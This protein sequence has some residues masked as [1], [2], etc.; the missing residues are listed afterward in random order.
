MI[1]CHVSYAVLPVMKSFPVKQSRNSTSVTLIWMEWSQNLPVEGQGPV[2]AYMVY[3]QNVSDTTDKNL[4]YTAG[5]TT[6][7]PFTVDGLLP[8]HSYLFCVA[9]VHESGAIGPRSPQSYYIQT[10]SR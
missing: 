2:S 7:G 3:Y 5:P 1:I 4:W 8:G 10:C 6:A 9:A